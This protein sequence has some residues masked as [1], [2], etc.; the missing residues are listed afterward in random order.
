MIWLMTFEST[1]AA[2]AAQKTFESL[3]YAFTAM[4][5]PADIEA[6]CG[7]ALRFEAE[8]SAAALA[9]ANKACVAKGFC[10]LYEQS[11]EGYL[12]VS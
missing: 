5:R 8:S 1:Y 11:S 7:I 9:L 4:T 12:L 10:A 6:G 3:E 2:L